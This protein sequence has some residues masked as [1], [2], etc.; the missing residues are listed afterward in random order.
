MAIRARN[1][2]NSEAVCCECKKGQSQVLNMFDF[3]IG[4]HVF[5][6]C[7][8]CNEEILVK[9]LKAECYKNS[10]LKSQQDMKIIQNRKKLK[11]RGNEDGQN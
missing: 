3:C 8:E 2:N 10:R 5:T 11:Y 7:D 6:I 9:S 4:G 1:N